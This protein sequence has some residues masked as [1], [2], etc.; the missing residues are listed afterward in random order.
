MGSTTIIGWSAIIP[1]IRK[2]KHNHFSANIYSLKILTFS[3]S[4]LEICKLGNLRDSTRNNSNAQYHNHTM[5]EEMIRRA[6][7]ADAFK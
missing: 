5:Q 3:R 4:F 1:K 6:N 7:V 2:Q